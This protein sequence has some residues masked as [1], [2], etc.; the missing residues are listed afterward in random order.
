MNWKKL[1]ATTST[2]HNFHA[3]IFYSL[4]NLRWRGLISSAYNSGGGSSLCFSTIDSKL[5]IYPSFT[6]KN[7]ATWRNISSSM[8]EFPFS[9]QPISTCKYFGISELSRIA[10]WI[11]CAAKIAFVLWVGFVI[12]S[13]PFWP[14]CSLFG[15]YKN[16]IDILSQDSNRTVPYGRFTRM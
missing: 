12:S 4:V 15:S 7:I 9:S 16:T 8:N 6:R 2:K 13:V 14:I 1:D 5:G 3:N 11:H 10:K